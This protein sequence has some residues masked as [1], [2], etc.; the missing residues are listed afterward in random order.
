MEE[1]YGRAYW[2]AVVGVGIE[3]DRNGGVDAAVSGPEPETIVTA[4]RGS[5][6]DD[7]PTHANANPSR[8]HANTNINIGFSED[9]GYDCG[10]AGGNPVSGAGSGSRGRRREVGRMVSTS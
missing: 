2:G 5:E 7:V 8:A 4:T 6:M 1:V 10:Y 9:L 3:N